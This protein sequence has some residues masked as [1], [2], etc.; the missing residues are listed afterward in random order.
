MTKCS[1]QD[2]WLLKWQS[3]ASIRI[4]YIFQFNHSMKSEEKKRSGKKRRRMGIVRCWKMFN[5]SFIYT[6]KNWGSA[7]GYNLKIKTR[8]VKN[9]VDNRINDYIK[10]NHKS[11]SNIVFFS[12][13]FYYS[14]CVFFSVWFVVFCCCFYCLLAIASNAPSP[15]EKTT[16]SS[17]RT[18]TLVMSVLQANCRWLQ[19]VEI[20]INR[21]MNRLNVTVVGTLVKLYAELEWI[22]LYAQW[23]FA[24]LCFIFRVVLSLFRMRFPYIAIVF[25]VAGVVSIAYC[26]N[27]GRGA[28]VHSW[29]LCLKYSCTSIAPHFVFCIGSH[30]QCAQCTLHTHA[31]MLS[32]VA[33][34]GNTLD[35]NAYSLVGWRRICCCWCGFFSVFEARLHRNFHVT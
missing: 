33:S 9:L 18:S 24:S 8:F 15:N 12:F 6:L 14:V 2:L 23:I 29:H 19:Q 7:R 34:F 17:D 35:Q 11:K 1:T 5:K 27:I 30:I 13:F 26:M 3:S 10:G 22:E 20:G 25:V 4:I 32:I 31:H 16:I 28:Y 21:P